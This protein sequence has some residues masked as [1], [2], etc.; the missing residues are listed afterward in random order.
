[1]IVTSPLMVA[2]EASFPLYAYTPP[3]LGGLG[4]SVG[5]LNSRLSGTGIKT[6]YQVRLIG[7]IMGIAALFGI[8]LT[9]AAFPPIHNKLGTPGSL[10]VC[11][12]R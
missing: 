2:Y 6:D 7:Y 5:R 9:I 8:V 1:M 4:L 11:A 10:L 12:Y 3:D